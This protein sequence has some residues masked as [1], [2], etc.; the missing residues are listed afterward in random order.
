MRPGDRLDRAII[1]LPFGWM[2]LFFLVPL[3]I[4]VVMSVTVSALTSPPV[5]FVDR[6]PFVSLASWSRLISDPIYIRAFITSLAN[7]AMATATCLLI[8]YPVALAVAKASPSLRSLWLM[9]VI[10]PFW[11]SFLLRVFAWIGLLGGNSWFNR[12]LTGA[13]N[14]IVPGPDLSQVQLLN[15]NFA[16]VLVMTYSYLPF[17]ILPLYATLEKLDPA[18]DEAAADLGSKP[19]T[20]FC[21]I[22]WPLSRPGVLAGSM[23]TFIPATGELLIP[24][25]VGNSANPMLGGLI[26]EEFATAHDWPM[27]ATLATMLLMVMLLAAV[28]RQRLSKR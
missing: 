6:W 20:V 17:M 25:L 14:L 24:N 4:V 18:L 23:L 10:L 22:T 2:L 7:A 19:F 5:A 27:A 1:A 28:F 12:L 3:L 13:H 16:V 11:T 9:L 8:G 26:Q 21:D 15:T